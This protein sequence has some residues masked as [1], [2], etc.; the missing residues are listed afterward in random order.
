MMQAVTVRMSQTNA[1]GMHALIMPILSCSGMHLLRARHSKLL[2]LPWGIYA[3]LA[4]FGFL[5]HS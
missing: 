2:Q 5:L 1:C 4:I 3:S